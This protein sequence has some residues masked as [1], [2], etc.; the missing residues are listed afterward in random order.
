[1]IPYFEMKGARMAI[2]LGL[3][4]LVLVLIL[5]HQ[6]ILTSNRIDGLESLLRAQDATISNMLGAAV[7]RQ[8]QFNEFNSSLSDE[9]KKRDEYVNGILNELVIDD[10]ASANTRAALQRIVQRNEEHLRELENAHDSLFELAHQSLFC[11]ARSG[12]KFECIGVEMGDEEPIYTFMCKDC[13]LQYD[14]LD[15]SM[16]RKEEVLAKRYVNTTYMPKKKRSM[17]KGK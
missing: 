9:L 16:S 3:F 6:L 14:I 13:T 17:K 8:K 4:V 12:H 1:M 7:N 2:A 11:Q 5:L 10:A 15:S